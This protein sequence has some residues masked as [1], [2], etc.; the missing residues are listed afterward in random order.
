ML[1]SE[2]RLILR[3]IQ[4]DSEALT[5]SIEAVNLISLLAVEALLGEVTLVALDWDLAMAGQLS[6]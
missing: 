3:G 4:R 2:H 6:R 5:L 1:L